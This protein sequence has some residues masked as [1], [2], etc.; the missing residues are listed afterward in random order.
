MFENLK[1]FKLFLI[2][3]KI[4]LMSSILFLVVLYVYIITFK[5]VLKN[6]SQNI[7]FHFLRKNH[8]T[9]F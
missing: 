3:L 9:I 8:K 5:T 7:L 6:I 1:C 4:T 2:I